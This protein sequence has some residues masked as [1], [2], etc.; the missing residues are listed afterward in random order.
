LALWRWAQGLPGRE[1]GR[2]AAIEATGYSPRT[3]ETII[4]KFSVMGKLERIGEGRATRYRVVV[5]FIG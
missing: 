1:F 5:C 2:K 3:A 4:K